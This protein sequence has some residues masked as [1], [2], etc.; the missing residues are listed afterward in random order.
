MLNGDNLNIQRDMSIAR[1]CEK[2]LWG[3]AAGLCSTP[4]SRDDL[5]KLV[6][7]GDCTI[8]E[9]AHGYRK[10]G[11]PRGIFTVPYLCHLKNN[12]KFTALE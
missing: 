7:N 6:A 5:T 10:E 2:L 4:E 3:R 11:G 9:M 8:G 1:M 12:S